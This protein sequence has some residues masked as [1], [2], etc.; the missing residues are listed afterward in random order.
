[1]RGEAIGQTGP[2]PR[3]SSIFDTGLRQVRESISRID[4]LTQEVHGL[5]WQCVGMP[6]KP[7]NHLSEVSAD[8]THI[9]AG[10]DQLNVAINRLQQ[11][12]GQFK[13]G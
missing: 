7:P 2:A 6:D 1:M 4:G 11:A 9:A 3:P 13:D 5:Y 10:L 12:I 8:P